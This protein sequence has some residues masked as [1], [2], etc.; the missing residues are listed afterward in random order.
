MNRKDIKLNVEN[1][2]RIM[3]WGN[4]AC[5]YNGR[6]NRYDSK[7]YLKLKILFNKYL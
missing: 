5:K 7:L 6:W 3:Q 4:E 1:I 2:E